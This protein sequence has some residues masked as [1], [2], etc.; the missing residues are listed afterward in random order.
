MNRSLTNGI[1][2]NSST[3]IPRPFFANLRQEQVNQPLQVA[4]LAA[5]FVPPLPQYRVPCS[6]PRSLLGLLAAVWR[7][8]CKDVS[9]LRGKLFL[10]GGVL[11]GFYFLETKRYTK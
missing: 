9:D 11:D 10:L 3:F 8:V 6:G 7:N 4:S 1:Y 5:Y 2:Q